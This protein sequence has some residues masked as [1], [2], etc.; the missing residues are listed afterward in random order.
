MEQLAG[1]AV[2]GFVGLL[3]VGVVWAWVKRRTPTV[4]RDVVRTTGKIAGGALRV[5]GGV[6]GAVTGLAPEPRFPRGRATW[7]VVAVLAGAAALGYATW[8]MPPAAALVAAVVVAVAGR[9]TL[10]DIAYAQGQQLRHETARWAVG[11]VLLAATQAATVG[12]TLVVAAEPALLRDVT[13]DHDLLTAGVAAFQVLS[14]AGLL[15]MRLRTTALR[16]VPMQ[17]TAPEISYLFG[18]TEEDAQRAGTRARVNRKTGDVTIDRLPRGARGDDEGL[19]EA[20]AAERVAERIKQI[21][22]GLVVR[23]HTHSY[24][25]ASPRTPEEVEVLRTLAASGGAFT[26]P[27]AEQS[28]DGTPVQTVPE[29]PRLTRFVLGDNAGATRTGEV[30]NSTP[31]ILS[32]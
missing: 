30:A 15:G 28:L 14:T 1:Y 11:L 26:G 8:W 25:R 13:V 32:M 5:T 29:D 3:V 19:D 20:M 18:C 22:P 31:G 12:A 16:K 17:W 10:V 2:V 27:V 7:V 4:V 6:A 23:E 24:L 21:Q 9:P